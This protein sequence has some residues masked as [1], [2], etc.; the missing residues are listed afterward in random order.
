ME[1]GVLSLPLRPVALVAAQVQTLQH[2]SGGRVVLGVGIGGFPGSP[3]WRAVGAPA[4][5]RER[6][7]DEALRVLPGLIRGE[8]TKAGDAEVTLSLGGDD[9]LRQAE[10]PAAARARAA[11]VPRRRTAP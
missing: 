9:L 5:D 1:F 3:F 8:A 10:T 11:T 4:R 7:T 2:R 6:R